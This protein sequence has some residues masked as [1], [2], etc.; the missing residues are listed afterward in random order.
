MRY[1]FVLVLVA[2]S[3]FGQAK[4]K[5]IGVEQF[6]KLRQQ[7]N[8]VVLDVRTPKEFAAGHIPGATNIDWNG[9]DFAKRAAALDKSK[10]YLVH[11]AVGGRSAKASDKMAALQFTNVYNLEGGMKAWEKAGKPVAK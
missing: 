11:C 5:N 4:F 3:A 10:T 7:T 1:A 6:D 9:A 8:I 2:L